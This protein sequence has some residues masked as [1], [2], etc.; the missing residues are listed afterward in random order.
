[1]KTPAWFKVV[2]VVAL[3]WNLL[4][5]IAFFFDLRLSPEDLAKL[6]EAQQAL[7]AA[8]PGWAVAAT[9]IAVFGGVLGSIG[10]ILGKRWA[11]PVLVLSLL[12][13]LVQDFGLFVL[14]DGASLAGPVAVV[15]Q[16]I[17]LVVGVGLVLLSRK[18]IARGWLR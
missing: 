15:M 18:G 13:I 9:A 5:C 8:R 3:L 10:M 12:G 17:V 1:M 2:A 7:Y 4:G 14:A 11:L 16:G 6:P